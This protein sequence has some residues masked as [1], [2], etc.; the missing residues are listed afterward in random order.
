MTTLQDLL[1]Q[2]VDH[3]RAGRYDAAK[4]LYAAIVAHEPRLADPTRLLALLLR[5]SEP[6]RAAALARR[7]TALEPDMPWMLSDLGLVL[8]DTGDGDGALRALTRAAHLAPLPLPALMALGHLHSAAARPQ[9][10]EDAFRAVLAIQPDHHEATLML[11]MLAEDA[12]RPDAAIAWFHHTLIRHPALPEAVFNLATVHHTEGR[13]GIASTLY[14]RLLRLRPGHHRARVALGR[15]A[16]SLGNPA[17]AETIFRAALAGRT[18]SRTASRTEGDGEDDK[19][20]GEA[21]RGLDRAIRYRAAAT[22]GTAAASGDGRI[23][24]VVRGPFRDTSGYAHLVRRFVRG[25]TARQ[26]AIDLIDLNVD[27][28]PLMDT[29][30]RDPALER[31]DRPIRARSALTFAIPSIVEP[32][33][34]L[35]PVNFSMFEAMS[36]PPAWVRYASALPW[37]IVPTESS[38]QAWMSAGFPEDRLQL[39][40][41]GVDP[42]QTGI[43]PAACVDDLGRRLSDYRVRVLNISDMVDRK[44]L[45]GLLR[46]WFRVTGPGDDAALL[47]KLG[48]GLAED[49]RRAW[50][51]IKAV[52]QSVGKRLEQAAPLFLVQG[53]LSDGEMATLYAACT[54]Y[55]S[56]SHGEGWDLPMTQAGAAGLTLIAPDHS[57]YA[58]YL[59]AGVA[60][61]I[62]SRPAPATPP[63]RGL[64]WWTPDEDVA[65]AVLAEVVA[66]RMPP[67]SARTHLLDR[68]GWGAACDR[69]LA[70]LRAV[71]GL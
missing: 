21:A 70:V 44:N 16:L 34:G 22:C 19:T 57:A 61:M 60:H 5:Q 55:L 25:L 71:D 42:A 31:F 20:W 37:I 2:A 26:V 36:V 14:C 68:F 9:E 13:A 4:S 12:S 7:A 50:P 54:H 47:L 65:A 29:R 69:L 41:L 48:K 23:G 39:C 51:F 1:N 18:A 38:R 10:A 40:P 49:D 45:D 67:R 64:T 27:F 15:L 28:V 11:G 66:G 3:H 43:V 35:T 46:T 53:V 52:A 33:P 24:L 32:I 58:T 63:Y 17:E 62:P 59:H 6:V 30:V 8:K 56:L